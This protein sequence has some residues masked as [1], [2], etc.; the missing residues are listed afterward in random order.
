MQK[1]KKKG[2]QSAVRMGREIAVR[3]KMRDSRDAV[4]KREWVRERQCSRS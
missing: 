1:E 4:R 3:R 2:L